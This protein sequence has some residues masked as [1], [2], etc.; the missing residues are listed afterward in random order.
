M[1][2]EHSESQASLY[3]LGA[4]SESDSQAFE[5]ALRSQPQLRALVQEFRNATDLLP[6]A[7][8]PASPS[9]E[10]KAKVFAAIDS[11]AAS[12]K[13]VGAIVS[14]G[15]M[16][17]VPWALAACFAVLCVVLISVG[18]NLRDQALSLSDRLEERNSEAAE[19]KGRLDQLQTQTVATATN[20]EQRLLNVEKQ[21]IAR[22]D[23]LGRQS[24]ALTNQLFRDQADL[25][26]RLATSEAG[27]TQL[28][29]EKKTLEEAIAILQI[30]GVDRFNNA[31]VSIL[32]PTPDG[33][34]GTVGASVWI[35]QDQRGLVAL[36][37]LPGFTNPAAQ[38][39]QLWLID[40]NSPAPISGGVFQPDASG[41]VRFAF[42]APT[43]K[44]IDRFA[45]SIEPKGGAPR[46]TGRIVL[47]G[48]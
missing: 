23:D 39:Y 28:A 4:L 42:A 31:K 47:A 22:I 33:S 7:F 14:P 15:W 44:T 24:A 29:R 45:V 13:P 21:A 36:D 3:V 43:V 11:P 17:W 19:L 34:P 12:I 16:E 41:S 1:I 20:Y 27:A 46:P 37:K 30:S 8:P 10:L 26:R 9:S 35:A 25:K 48:N 5:A 6:A 32:H 2:D 40:P 38:D 18:K